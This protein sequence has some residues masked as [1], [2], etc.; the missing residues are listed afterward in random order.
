MLFRS[1]ERFRGQKIVLEEVN[2]GTQIIAHTVA[3]SIRDTVALTQHA[4]KFGADFA[5]MGNP[6]LNSR[7]PDVTFNFFKAVCAETDLGIG[8]FNTAIS[9]YSLSP[10]QIAD[11]AEIENIICVKDAQPPA[12]ILETRKLVKGKLVLCDPLETNLLDN[13]LFYGDQ[14][15]MSSP[16]PYLFQTPGN[17][18]IRDYYKAAAAGR[19]DEARR[20][21]ATLARVRVVEQKWI[22]APWSL[23]FL[24]KAAVKAWSEMVGLS[25][26]N[27]RL[28]LKPLTQA[29]KDELRRDLV[30][31][32]VI[33][34]AAIAAE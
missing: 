16:A 2:G 18:P 20:I 17:L 1:E 10:Q 12:H 34:K 33:E 29:Q 3:A 7:H 8:L 27:P 4:Q 28:P 6:P 14:V 9:G 23:G 15:H 31:A 32:G 26:G 5:I 13:M 11:L 22:N 30:W 25:G 24:P 21:W 19:E